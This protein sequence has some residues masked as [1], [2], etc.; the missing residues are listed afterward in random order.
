MRDP[1]PLQ[2]FKQLGN[3]WLDGG[4]DCGGQFGSHLDAFRLD[5]PDD[6]IFRHMSL[7]FGNCK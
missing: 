7:Q 4:F 5:T 1:P 6:K 2:F 3:D